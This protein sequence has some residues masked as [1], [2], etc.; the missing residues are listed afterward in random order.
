M[1]DGRMR[2]EMT[3][4]SADTCVYAERALRYAHTP[5]FT[6]PGEST[7]VIILESRKAPLLAELLKWAVGYAAY[8]R[9][10][11]DTSEY[12]EEQ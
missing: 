1:N 4:P 8:E 5:D 6:R 11:F 10:R 2:I 3:F 9:I 7:I 12:V